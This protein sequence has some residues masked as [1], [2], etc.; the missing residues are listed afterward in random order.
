MVRK[1]EG[2]HTNPAR[3]LEDPGR[4]Q[5]LEPEESVQEV[6]TILMINGKIDAWGILLVTT[7]RKSVLPCYSPPTWNKDSKGDERLWEVLM[8]FPQQLIYFH[9]E[10]AVCEKMHGRSRYG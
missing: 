9:Q 1:M 4:C 2:R 8:S 5:S 3:E 10:P 7:I 6:S